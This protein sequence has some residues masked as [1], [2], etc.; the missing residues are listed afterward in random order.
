M[1]NQ[2]DQNAQTVK[3]DI[4]ALWSDVNFDTEL[5]GDVFASDPKKKA[6]LT[7]VNHT[8]QTDND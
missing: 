6:M 2:K 5:D 1:Q 7:D 3:V 4:S 8:S